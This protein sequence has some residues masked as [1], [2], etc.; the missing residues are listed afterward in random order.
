M[1]ANAAATAAAG[2]V[3]SCV[4]LKQCYHGFAP[5]DGSAA[6]V[7]E[8][9]QDEVLQEVMMMRWQRQQRW[10]WPTAAAAMRHETVAGTSNAAGGAAGAVRPGPHGG[11]RL[12]SVDE[13]W[14]LFELGQEFAERAVSGCG[15][16]PLHIQLRTPHQ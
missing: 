3:T 16:T 11:L 4:Q 10:Q 9:Q 5:P 6:L 8:P 14:Q 1:P 15:H 12:V 2:G 13:A 7:I